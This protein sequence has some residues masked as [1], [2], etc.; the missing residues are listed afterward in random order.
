MVLEKLEHIKEE[1]IDKDF[2]KDCLEVVKKMHD[3]GDNH[4]D[5][6]PGNI[7]K[8]KFDSCKIIDYEKSH[9]GTPFFSNFSRSKP[10]RADIAALGRSLISMKYAA[11]ISQEFN[12]MLS[13]TEPNI[14]DYA[15]LGFKSMTRFFV[16]AR[17]AFIIPLHANAAFKMQMLSDMFSFQTVMNDGEIL[18]LKNLAIA[19]GIIQ[20]AENSVF[21]NCLNGSWEGWRPFDIRLKEIKGRDSWDGFRSLLRDD[22]IAEL[23]INM[24]AGLYESIEPILIHQVLQDD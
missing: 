17:N 21:Y 10:K 19:Q 12:S 13:F 18:D 5:L 3:D 9:Y 22:P 14:G 20:A 24:A 8:S 2:I 15:L 23:L 7:M 4:G 11:N 1:D 6:S 16:P